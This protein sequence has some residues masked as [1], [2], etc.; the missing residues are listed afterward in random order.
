MYNA[1][2]FSLTI[3]PFY[4]SIN[5]GPSY[6]WSC[7]KRSSNQPIKNNKINTNIGLWQPPLL[8]NIKTIRLWST[9]NP[10]RKLWKH[11]PVVLFHQKC[12]RYC[13]MDVL[14]AR[15]ILKVRLGSLVK[16]KKIG[17]SCRL[18]QNLY[19][20]YWNSEK[21]LFKAHSNKGWL[22]RNLCIFFRILK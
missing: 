10:D 17:V 9:L 20:I 15:S 7:W 19:E 5:W 1:C 2:L 8:Q 22:V 3:G 12:T 11:R 14:I 18:F 21:I 6:H 4:E 13:K 16:I